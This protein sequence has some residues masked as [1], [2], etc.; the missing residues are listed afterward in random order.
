MTSGYVFNPMEAHQ[1]DPTISGA[2]LLTRP[3]GADVIRIQAFTQALRYTLD[4]STP[5]ASAGFRLAA[6]EMIEIPLGASGSVKVI[7]ETATGSVQW[8]WGKML[9]LAGSR[10]ART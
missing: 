10:P 6:N 2:T 5:T 3:T 8:Q 4:G 1:A 9:P 7:E